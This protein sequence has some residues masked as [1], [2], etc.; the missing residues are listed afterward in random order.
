MIR[1]IGLPILAT[2]ICVF[3]Q[4]PCE[5]LKS[6]SLA[7]AVITAAETVPNQRFEGP[8]TSSGPPAHCRVSVVL[9][10]SPDSHIETEVWLPVTNWN[11]K[12]LA[13]GNGGWAGNVPVRSSTG[14]HGDGYAIASTDTG[15]QGDATDASFAVSHPDKIKDFAYRA[16]HEMTIQSKAIIAAFYGSGPRLSY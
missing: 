3:A 1:L 7:N 2:T 10:P 14:L 15:H 16:V 13:L 6:L 5:R 8:G 4:T 12:F 9:A 11:R